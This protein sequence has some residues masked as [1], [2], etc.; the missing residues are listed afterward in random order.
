VLAKDVKSMSDSKENFL[1]SK[2]ENVK[3]HVDQNVLEMDAKRLSVSK[4]TDAENV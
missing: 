2:I 4:E 3:T 1:S